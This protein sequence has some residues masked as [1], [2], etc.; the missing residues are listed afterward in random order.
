MDAKGDD[1][2]YQSYNYMKALL[3]NPKI[4]VMLAASN[5]LGMIAEIGSPLW[6]IKSKEQSEFS[7]WTSRNPEDTL[8]RSF[9][10]SWL[11]PEII[12]H[13]SSGRV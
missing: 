9:S 2:M 4:N 1:L 10:K 8:V 12:Q 5:T 13:T 6:A 3:P 7:N 11:V